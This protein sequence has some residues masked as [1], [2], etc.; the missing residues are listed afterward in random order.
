MPP[1]VA[2]QPAPPPAP[3]EPPVAEPAPD[4]ETRA[5]ALVE[6]LAHHRYDDA[7]ARFDAELVQALPRPAL[8][9]LWQK[10]EDAGGALARI[11]GAESTVESD[12]HV[13]RVIC[14][15]AHFRKVVRV[16]L[17]DDGAVA[18]LFIEPH[19]RDLEDAA[20]G[21]VDRLAHDDFQ[22]AGSTFDAILR[23][24]LPPDKL[25]ALWTRVV[26]RSG[27]FVEVDRAAIAAADGLS[28]VLLTCRFAS[29][30]AVVKVVYDMRDQV[31][32]L[33]ILPG[34]VLSPW[35]APPY[36][37]PD[38]FVERDITV[39]ASPALPGVLTLPKGPGP[40]PAVV[41][42][43][44]SGPSD[45]D[46]SLGPNRIFKDLAWGLAS[47]DIAVIRYVKRTHHI[48]QAVASIQE[49]VVDGALAAVDLAA[50]TRE[51][52]ARRIVLL[53]HSQGGYLAPRL[54]TETPTI[55]GIILLAGPSRP[56]QD[57]L[58]DQLSYFLKLDPQNAEKQRMVA[59]ARELKARI[60]DPALDPA[61]FLDLPG[62]ERERGSYFL[63]L[64]GYRPTDVAAGLS[65]P[66]LALQG[67]R[68]Y[69]VTSTD[70][71]GWRR[72][73]ASRPKVTFKR[74][75]ALNHLFIAGSG[76]PRPG[77][78]ESPGHVEAAVVNDIAAFV[79][80]L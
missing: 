72:A 28:A 41:L 42:V 62:G 3:T 52:D 38:R 68:D 49:E 25:R 31:A 8:T 69:Q 13:V 39:G 54:A 77:E 50:H 35:R 59:A 2:S 43:H 47:R 48:P 40:F 16:V 66:I 64:R 14:R 17:G 55:A 53:G 19:A 58:V 56:L 70:F 78:Y 36:A 18:G 61:L 44:G 51:I 12:L 23:G 24:S 32:G 57:S 7:I 34:D 10:I 65:I 71:D 74:Y 4:P 6:D 67:D 76:T 37:S 29:G 5:R 33:F 21:I 9:V 20:R 46:A 22:G 60:E 15:F 73:L 1:P 79:G 80:R 30:S 11:E 63:S 27:A 75:P 26:K 45:A